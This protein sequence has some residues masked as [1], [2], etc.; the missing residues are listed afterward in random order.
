MGKLTCALAK[1]IDLLSYLASLGYQP[2]KIRGQD[3]WYLSPLRE[4]MTPSFKV[5]KKL[6]IWYDHGIGKGGDLIDFGTLYFGCTISDLLQKLSLQPIPS[7][8]FH[9]PLQRAGLALAVEKKNNPEPK[10]VIV[11]TRA[12]SDKPLIDYLGE[13]GI[14]ADVASRTCRE[15]DFLL[16]GKKHT[17]IGFLN[18]AGGYELRS[19]NFKGSSTP[20]DITFIN[21][22]AKE[23]AVFEGFFNYLSYLQIHNTQLPNLTNCLVLNSLSFFEKSRPLMEKHRQV[24]LYLDRDKAGI[25]CTEQSL[26]TNHHLYKDQSH[27][28]KDYKDLNDWLKSRPPDVKQSRRIGRSF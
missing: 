22:G 4:E 19:K 18:N 8:S 10:I 14:S 27:F 23:V 3:H 25:K 12:I 17:V 28:Y 5:D 20:K 15:V 26:K 21:N 1:Q 11:D 6:N 16:Y 9:P 24:N 13:R 2:K 7:F